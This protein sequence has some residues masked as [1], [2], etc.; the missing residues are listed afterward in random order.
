MDL[1]VDDDYRTPQLDLSG[2][3]E[4]WLFRAPADLDITKLENIEVPVPTDS[5][6]GVLKRCPMSDG[7]QNLVFSCGD[8]RE[9]SSI[10]PLVTEDP[11]LG[12][13]LK[14]GSA[15][16]RHI[17][18]TVEVSGP[19]YPDAFGGDEDKKEKKNVVPFAYAP[20]AQVRG[21]TVYRSSHA[22]ATSSSSSSSLESGNAR[23]R[24]RTE[25]KETMNEVSEDSK[26]MDS[27]VEN[28]GVAPVLAKKAKKKTKGKE[29]EEAAVTQMDSPAAKEDST[30]VVELDDGSEKKKKKKKKKDKKKED[31][32][33]VVEGEQR[34]G[35][36]TAAGGD[37]NRS[38][39][40]EQ[41]IKKKE[42]KKKA[43]NKSG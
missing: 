16:K 1:I 38:P 33:D 20:R 10:R 42:K 22:D 8:L 14:L 26:I 34:Q 41:K 36:A 5:S 37:S 19:K 9:S 39:E 27:H 18:I 12:P 31:S 17:N 25:A 4:L 24:A 7:K 2:G 11:D 35:G 40:K 15:F 32:V 43:K 30:E 6:S 13:T 28:D 23:K 3:K 29:P 21:L